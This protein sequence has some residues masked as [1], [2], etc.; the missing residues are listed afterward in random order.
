MWLAI[1]VFKY[2]AYKTKVAFHIL[3]PRHV[4]IWFSI[5]TYINL[6]YWSHMDQH[7]SVQQDL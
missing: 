2:T 7:F 6:P 4:S 5:Y 3:H 1:I